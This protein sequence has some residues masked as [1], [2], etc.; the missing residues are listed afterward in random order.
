MSTGGGRHASKSFTYQPSARRKIQD[1]FSVHTSIPSGVRDNRPTTENGH[2]SSADHHAALPSSTT[3][4]PLRLAR[5]SIAQRVVKFLKKE[6]VDADSP[7]P[8]VRRSVRIM[9][10]EEEGDDVVGPADEGNDDGDSAPPSG[11]GVGMCRT[12]QQKLAEEWPKTRGTVS[13]DT[14]QVR[15]GEGGVHA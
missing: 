6:E 2:Q 10:P 11:Q 14:K 15:A 13:T 1:G 12:W 8:I 5:K 7:Q 9:L 4:S 3:A